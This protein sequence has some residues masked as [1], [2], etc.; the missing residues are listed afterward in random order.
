MDLEGGL[1]RPK[2]QKQPEEEANYQ[3]ELPEPPEVQVLGTLVTEPEPELPQLVVDAEGLA[4]QAADDDQH[5]RP[6]EYVDAGPL[7]SGLFA[8]DP[9]RQEKAAAHPG[10]RDPEDGELEV[11][12]ASQVVG[13]PAG[14]VEP[15]KGSC[16]H[17][18]V[19]EHASQK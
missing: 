16:L 14:D 5:Q 15:V 1:E 13:Q 3:Q 6:E 4:Y 10:R 17:T 2:H 9:R 18:I 11:P 7:V 12:G 8:T 19:G